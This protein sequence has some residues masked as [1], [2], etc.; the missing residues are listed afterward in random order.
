VRRRWRQRRE[1]HS[2]ESA[3]EIGGLNEGWCMEGRSVVAAAE[4]RVGVVHAGT[5]G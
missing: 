5:E 2:P 3:S 1:I 4:S